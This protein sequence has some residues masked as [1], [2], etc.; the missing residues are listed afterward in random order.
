MGTKTSQS[1]LWPADDCL[2]TALTE[3]IILWVLW[4][5]LYLEKSLLAFVL[6]MVLPYSPGLIHG[7]CGYDATLVFSL[8]AKLMLLIPHFLFFFVSFLSC[9]LVGDA[10]SD[11]RRTGKRR[12]KK[13]QRKHCNSVLIVITESIDSH[14]YMR[15][16][17]CSQLV[18]ALARRT[19]VA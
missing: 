18:Q 12:R 19:A 16:M 11:G 2:E 10:I 3:S 13:K 5:M 14:E 4:S 7:L 1:Q 17:R 9:C 15:L 6:I 8:H